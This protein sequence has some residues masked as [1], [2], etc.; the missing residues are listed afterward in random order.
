MLGKTF[1]GF[2]FVF[3]LEANNWKQR[4]KYYALS[5]SKSGEAKTLL[6]FNLK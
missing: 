4:L 5:Y 2:I 1:G 3:K 6:A